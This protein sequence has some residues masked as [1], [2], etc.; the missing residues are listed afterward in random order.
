MLRP[1]ISVVI[2]ARDE[3]ESLPELYRSIASVLDRLDRSAEVVCVDHGSRDGTFA[4]LQALAARDS[5]VTVV[6]L[7]PGGGK[8]AALLAGFDRARAAVVITIDADLQ[9]DPEDIPVLLAKLDE[10]YDVVSGWRRRR[11]DRFLDRR[12]PSLLANSLIR[13]VTGSPV[14]DHGAG[15]KA[16]R[17]EVLDAVRPRLF[18]GMHRFIAV[19]CEDAGARV[20]EVAVHHHPRRFGRSKYGL[21][22][23]WHVLVDLGTVWLTS[24]RRSP[25]V[26]RLGELVVRGRRRGPTGPDHGVS[27]VVERTDDRHV[28]GGGGPGCSSRS[29]G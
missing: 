20:T 25:S 13:G 27:E 4:L 24:P 26:G 1:D 16:Y 21:A 9:D 2:P 14:H 8:V 10:G 17:R 28:P 6:R 18:G 29:D 19:L 5:R 3:A 15:L 7:R 22:R 12:L 23:T 11:E